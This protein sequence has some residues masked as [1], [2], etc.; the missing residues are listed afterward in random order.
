MFPLNLLTYNWA[1]FT[2]STINIIYVAR[3]VACPNLIVVQYLGGRG[4]KIFVSEFVANLAYIVSS[5]SA[6]AI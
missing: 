3:N 1:T 4:R 6:K 2:V 5:K